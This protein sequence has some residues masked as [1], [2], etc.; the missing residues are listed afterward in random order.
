MPNTVDKFGNLLKVTNVPMTGSDV[1]FT[2]DTLMNRFWIQA[3][4]TTSSMYLAA[5]SASHAGFT[6]PNG[7]AAPPAE[8]R[9]NDLAGQT[10]TLN[11]TN[12]T[13]V[14]IIEYLSHT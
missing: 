2:F 14:Q 9:I 6:L 10:I 5:A 13:T 3:S 1:A 7:G 11:G 12:A 4:A 8:F